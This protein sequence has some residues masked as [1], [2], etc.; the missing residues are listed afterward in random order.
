MI[1]VLLGIA[2]A[3]AAAAVGARKLRDHLHER[4]QPG[5][6]QATAIHIMDFAEID[7][8]L[9]RQSCRCGGRFVSLGEGP[10]RGTRPLRVAHLEC[11]SCERE[12]RVYF[13][14]SEIRH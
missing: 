2:V 11:R 6:S 9:R 5:Q 7:L 3:I 12:R 14:L 4:S 13:D 8:E 10:V 1:S